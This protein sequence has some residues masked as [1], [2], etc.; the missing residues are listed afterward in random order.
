MAAAIAAMHRSAWLYALAVALA[1]VVIALVVRARRAAQGFEDE[2]RLPEGATTLT[3]LDAHTVGTVDC[4]GAA[5]GSHE[6]TIDLRIR[7]RD[8]PSVMSQLK[9]ELRVEQPML[10]V[11]APDG[12]YLLVSAAEWEAESRRVVFSMLRWN[13]RERVGL[14]ALLADPFFSD[15]GDAPALVDALPP[16]AEPPGDSSGEV[17]HRAMRALAGPDAGHCYWDELW[18]PP[19]K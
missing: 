12:R 4:L 18:G 11:G 10:A 17:V 19:P 3:R 2:Y 9:S 7:A 13:P 5:R 8:A 16:V 1:I 15:L 6:R 14:E